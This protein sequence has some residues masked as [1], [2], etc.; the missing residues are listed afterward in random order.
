M[1]ATM[2]YRFPTGNKPRSLAEHRTTTATQKHPPTTDKNHFRIASTVAVLGSV[3]A[4]MHRPWRG[5][6]ITRSISWVG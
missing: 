2:S 4:S 1:G 3:C 5:N 6:D